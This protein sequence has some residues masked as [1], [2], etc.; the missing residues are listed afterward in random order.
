MNT[1]PMAAAAVLL[2]LAACTDPPTT[3]RAVV[4]G[5]ATVAY[6]AVKFWD[7]GAT[8]SWNERATALAAA[9]GVDVNRMYAYLSYAQFRASEAAEATPGAYPPVTAA[10]AGASVAVLN[11][12]F[13]L[14]V[15]ANEE[16]L[17]VQERSAPWP[18]GQPPDFSVGEAIGRAIGARVLTF[19]QGDGIGLTDP[20][21]PPVG[22]PP[23]GPGRWIYTG[24]PIARGGLGARP[25]FMSSGSQ[26]RPPP[27][28]A[29][30]GPEYS[31]A[32]A[33][34]RAI[35]NTRTAAQIELANHWNV[36]Q[37]PRSNA[38]IMRVARD[39]IVAHHR[40][41]AEA[42]R[43]MFL[44]NAAAFDAVIGCFEAKYTYWYIRPPQA[45]P[46]LVTVFPAP[47]HPSY[48]AAHSCVSGAANGVLTAFFPSE[49]R[50]LDN[51]AAQSGL[52]R[53]YAGIH[54]RFDTDA[55]LALGRS[56]AAL[57]LAADLDLVAPLP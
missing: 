6:S 42:A 34:L 8:V 21:L 32:L 1:K 44:M 22:P 53:L 52:S 5:D 24:G 54:F 57:A 55:G 9:R 7:V 16:A 2:V 45:D 25:F 15:A 26:L 46:G 19:A 43:I 39:L 13:P 14:D 23:V 51:L 28:P 35:A 30:G 56:A 27:P 3:V 10:I 20:L 37:S 18:G 36:N 47:P 29:F 40:E 31:A 38:T 4:P 48:P 50:R 12:F 17:D 49:R 11:A 33:E 41:D